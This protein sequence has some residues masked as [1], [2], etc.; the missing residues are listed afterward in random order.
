MYRDP[1]VVR[2]EEQQDDSEV[3]QKS[4]TATKMLS[5]FRQMEENLA[6]DPLPAGPKPLKRFTPPPEPV[7]DES[8]SGEEVS[9]SEAD[10]DEEECSD[11]EDRGKLMD[12]DLLEVS[13]K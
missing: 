4:H 11:T 10:D 1:D 5:I 12:E 6:K 2:S 13:Q 7:R 3:V 8:S 9:E